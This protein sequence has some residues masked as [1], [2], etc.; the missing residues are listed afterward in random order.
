MTIINPTSIV[1]GDKDL[2]QRLI[3]EQMI[4]DLNLDVKVLAG[5]IIRDKNG[6]A[7]SS[8]NQYLNKDQYKISLTINI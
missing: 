4:N 6:L 5:P 7:L 1:L 3:L 2:Q 8:R